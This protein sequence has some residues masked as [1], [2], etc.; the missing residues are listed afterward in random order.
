M[1]SRVCM[2]CLHKIK[3]HIKIE[4][5]WKVEGLQYKEFWSVHEEEGITEHTLKL[6]HSMIAKAKLA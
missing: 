4:Q 5:D 3:C 6:D 1:D 2:T